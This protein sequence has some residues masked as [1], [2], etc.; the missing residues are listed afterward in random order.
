[1]RALV[2]GAGGFVGANLVRRL[3]SDGHQVAALAR[4]NADLWRL[5]DMGTEFEL[6]S[7]DLEDDETTTRACV[8]FR[9][10]VFFHLAAHGAY[11]WQQDLDRMLAVNARATQTLLDAAVAV[12]ARFIHAGSSSEYGYMDHP[13]RES[14]LARPNSHYAVTK[15]T[16]TMLCQLAGDKYGI[17]TAT[18]RLY[19]VYGPWEEPNRLM[20]TLIRSAMSGAWPP[21]AAPDTARDFVWVD[22]ACQ[23]FVSAS[24][25]ELP[26]PGAVFNIASETQTTLAQVVETATEV[27]SVAVPPE[28]GSMEQRAWD[29]T[30]WVGNAERARQHLDWRTTTDLR[31]GLSQFGAWFAERPELTPRYS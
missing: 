10:E 3:V 24:T 6:I 13:P 29:T 30:V 27:F 5:G 26:E 31:A 21:L 18:L 8:Q 20:P 12:D 14:E 28:W 25:S 16:A 19:S 4:P 15:L 22:D 11:S 2:T 23:A 7:A 1:M 17:P 9:P